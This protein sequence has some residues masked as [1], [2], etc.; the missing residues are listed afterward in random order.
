MT[1][2]DL[3]GEFPSIDEAQWKALA[4]ASLKGRP[5]ETLR[6]RTAD[7]ITVEPVYSAAHDAATLPAG[8]DRLAADMWTLTQRAD[9]PDSPLPTHRCWKTWKMV[10]AVFRWC[11][12]AA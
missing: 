11:C 4:E 3:A 6:S 1:H 9:M 5:F 7:G 12:R 10:P 2:L 8:P